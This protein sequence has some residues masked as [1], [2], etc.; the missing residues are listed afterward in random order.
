MLKPL[1]FRVDPETAH[2]LARHALKTLQHSRTALNFVAAQYTSPSAAL[3][4]HI[5]GLHFPNPVGI[6]AGFD[7][8]GEMVRALAALGFGFVEIGSVTPLPQAGNPKPRLFR[9]VAAQTLQNAMGFNNAGMEFVE[10]QLISMRTQGTL[11]TPLGVNVGKNKAT[12][13]DRAL[14]DYQQ[15]LTNLGPLANYLVINISS[16]NTPGLRDLQ[17]EVFVRDLF[18]MALAVTKKP[19]LLK[20]AP[21]MDLSAAIALSQFAV[22]H[23]AAGI[24]A[25][26]TTTDYSLLPGVAPAGGLSG[27]VLREKSFALLR[28]LARELFGK[29]VLI[30]VGGID[31]AEE[32]YRRL[33]TG[34]SLVQL[35]SSLVFHGPGLPH[36]INVELQ[37]LLTQDGAKHI[38]DIIGC[39]K[40]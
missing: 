36:R 8:N 10:Q 27:Q 13:A 35:Y 12:P 5:L 15:L 37:R 30:S 2:G 1:L 6:A 3:S 38:G 31:S 22:S 20:I 23:G 33:K 18:Q 29:T 26:N 39:D 40:A 19:V 32:V 11:A 24:I 17:N 4:Q 28:G 9:H 21:D 16:P 34:A 7:K 14:N 25:S